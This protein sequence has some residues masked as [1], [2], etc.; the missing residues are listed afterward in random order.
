MQI[1]SHIHS[2][3][4][5]DFRR[6]FNPMSSRAFRAIAAILSVLVFTGTPVQAGPVVFSDVIQLLGNFQNPPD[7]RLRGFSQTG[8]TPLAGANGAAPTSGRESTV[9]SSISGK[10]SDFSDSLLAG[11][12]VNATDAQR[13]VEVIA[14]GDVDGTICD[15]GDIWL[16]GGF[17]R[18]P[19]IFL[20]GIP[21]FFIDGDDTP[22]LPP[23][24]PPVPTPTPPVVVI[25]E[26]TSLLLFGT[27]LVAF[28]ASLRRRYGK[29]KLAARS[30][31][32]ARES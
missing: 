31:D 11:V 30:T 18:W 26:P 19:L 3:R 17:P 4:G 28:G 2:P 15:C 23:I 29:A 10:A 32:E 22:P 16:V 8:R 21:L 12:A 20:A 9:D 1:F 13:G 5:K 7:L 24:P 25:P 27:G 6:T 14:Q